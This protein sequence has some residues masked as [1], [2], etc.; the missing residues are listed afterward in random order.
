MLLS[1]VLV[2]VIHTASANLIRLC[3]ETKSLFELGCLRE[4]PQLDAR[5]Y[6][7]YGRP[8]S[9]LYFMNNTIVSSLGPNPERRLGF[10]G[11]FLAMTSDK[12][13]E[14]II[15][16]TVGQLQTDEKLWACSFAKG[17][18]KL[19]R[20]KL[21]IMRGNERPNWWCHPIFLT[22]HNLYATEKLRI[23]QRGGRSESG[24]YEANV[25]LEKDSDGVQRLALSTTESFTP[26]LYKWSEIRT[27]ELTGEPQ[28]LCI[29]DG[30]FVVSADCKPA[31][32]RRDG[33][34]ISFEDL[35]WVCD[36]TPD[37]EGEAHTVEIQADAQKENVADVQKENVADVQKETL[38]D[39]EVA[40]KK[41]ADVAVLVD[42][43][44]RDVD[45]GGKVLQILKEKPHDRCISVYM[46]GTDLG[47]NLVR[48]TRR[49]RVHEPEEE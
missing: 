13:A 34:Y 27:N 33:Q 2:T 18:L 20:K 24:T 39:G 16:N 19:F 23:I 9:K 46:M 6:F 12:E 31:E 40:D 35:L 29:V 41:D 17:P 4:E 3:A 49:V 21:L 14:Y 28:H 43:E 15:F 26:F 44:K 22:K 5:S 1:L 10:H 25:V 42:L 47:K 7:S 32:F 37:P 48:F 8:S 36:K 30:R 11:D 45:S 38:I